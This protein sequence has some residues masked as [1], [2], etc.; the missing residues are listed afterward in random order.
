MSIQGVRLKKVPE[1]KYLGSVIQEDKEMDKEV[2]SKIP[3]GWAKWKAAS[4]VLCDRRVPRK[5]K[6]K[7]Y[8]TV[9]RPV[10]KY[11][12]ECWAMKKAHEQRMHVGEM[13]MLGLMDGMTRRDRME[14]EYVRMYVGVES[15][16][17]V[18][19]QNRLR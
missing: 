4:G 17:D 2:T 8:R 13:R 7:F 10:L 1:Y 14:N 18:L 5:L 12:S 9:V 16:G 6:D 15:I 11:G 19:V 3:V